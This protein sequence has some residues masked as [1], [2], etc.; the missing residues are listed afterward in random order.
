MPLNFHLFFNWPS[1]SFCFW[2][3]GPFKSYI[4]PSPLPLFGIPVFSFFELLR[5]LNFR[6]NGGWGIFEL[7]STSRVQIRK[8]KF[9]IKRV[10][11]FRLKLAPPIFPFLFPTGRFARWDSAAERYERRAACRYPLGQAVRRDKVRPRTKKMEIVSHFVSQTAFLKLALER[12]GGGGG[13]AE[14]EDDAGF[15]TGLARWYFCCSRSFL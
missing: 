8:R 3:L 1:K 13:E 15:E 12:Y 4:F 11:N 14:G 2:A 5:V 9:E 7:K 10:L 6:L